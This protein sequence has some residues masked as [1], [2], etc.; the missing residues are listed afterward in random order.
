MSS[1]KPFQKFLLSRF[2]S[3]I[4]SALFSSLILLLLLFVRLYIVRPHLWTKSTVWH[5]SSWLPYSLV[6]KLVG[7]GQV[8]FL[9]WSWIGQLWR[10]CS[11]VWSARPQGHNGDGTS[12]NLSNICALRRLC[13]VRSLTNFTCF[14]LSI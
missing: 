2:L 10:M 11:V 4:S 1:S 12:L 7:F 5:S 9:S 14:S 13:P 8:L 3:L 6:S